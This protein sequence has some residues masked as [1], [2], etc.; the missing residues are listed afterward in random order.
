MPDDDFPIAEINALGYDVAF[1]G[2]K[3]HYGVAIM[4][5]AKASAIQKGFT[6]DSDDSQKRF[7]SGTFTAADGRPFTFINGYFPQGESR[8]HPVK[9]PGKEKFY[10]DLSSHLEAHHAPEDLLLVVGDMN[11]AP[12]DE[13]IGIGD[14]NRK[15]WLRDGKTSFLPEERAWI[16]ALNKWGL[17]DLFRHHYPQEDSLFSWFDYRSRGFERD[18]RRGLRIDLIMS[19]TG[20]LPLSLDSGID[21]DIRGMDKPSDHCPIWAELDLQLK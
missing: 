16:E 5:R 7:I 9:F 17:T 2:Q 11:V 20:T 13:D 4:Y 14:D 18:P 8:D 3:T 15:R 19:S 10:T 1:H 21:Y 6:T 12:V